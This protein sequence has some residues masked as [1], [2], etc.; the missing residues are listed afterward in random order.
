MSESDQYLVLVVDDQAD[1]N[2]IVTKR[3]EHR[4]YRVSVAE[5]VELAFAA[6]D[7]ER[8]DLVLLDITSPRVGGLDD[9]EQLRAD[10]ATS[11]I[12]VILISA[13]ADTDDIVR[14]LQYG[15]NDYVTKPIDMSVLQSR[16]ETHITG[17]DMLKTSERRAELLMR[18]AKRD[19]VRLPMVPRASQWRP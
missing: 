2:E 1:G 11:N 15:A 4:G 18:L 12:P 3:L 10:P 9:L 6:I 14:G 7:A 5:S 19:A 17:A 13:S 16:I 8:P